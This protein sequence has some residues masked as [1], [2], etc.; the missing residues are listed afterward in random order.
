M[1]F[2]KLSSDAKYNLATSG[3]MSYPLAE[4]PVK[5]EDLE[6]NGT[7]PYGYRPLVERIARYNGV[8]AECVM[9]AAG[10]SFANHLAMAASF[11]PGDEVLIEHPT[12]ELLDS[13]A[14][15]LGADLNRFERRFEEGFCLDPNEVERQISPRTKLIIVTNLHNPSGNYADENTIRAVGEIAKSHGARVLVDEVYL[16]SFY[17]NRPKPAF[18]Y[19]EHFVVTSSLTKAFGLS[20]IRC[21][22]VLSSPQLAHRMWRINDLYAATPAHPAE[23]ISVIALDHLEQVAARAKSL[24]DANRKSLNEFLDAQTTLDVYR[25]E[26]G[27]IVFPRLKK[28]SVEELLCLLHEKY[29]T[30]VVPGRFFDRPQHFRVGIG[31]DP[32]M[33]RTAFERLG[34]ALYEYARSV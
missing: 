20:G 33:T 27:T 34:S 8:S 12:Y 32:G 21:G 29:E 30:S 24:L 7:G 4:L 19:G 15:Y 28:G 9:T 31:G 11:D 5:I 14:L 17:E 1:E 3:I 10:T 26:H 6:I 2:A 16:E 25:P 23:L 18:H 13:T 22:W